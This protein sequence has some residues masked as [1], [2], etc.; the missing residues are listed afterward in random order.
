M[1]LRD[2]QSAM[3]QL[4][5]GCDG[6]DP[7][8]DF[9]LSALER[10]YLSFLEETAGFEFTVNLQRSWC[11]AR[12]AKAAFLTLSILPTEIRSLMLNEWLSLGGG[13]QSSMQAEA[14]GFLRFIS[15]RL[16]DPS[17]EFSVCMLEL[18]ALKASEGARHFERPSPFQLDSRHCLL[19][20]GHYAGLVRF[21][22][23][24]QDLLNALVERVPL[25]PV[26]PNAAALLVA[27][28][29]DRFHRPASRADV[30]IYE[31]LASP[32]GVKALLSEGFKR[33]SIEELLKDGVVEYVQ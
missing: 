13:T 29:L 16:T 21:H 27:P 11:A 32:M 10:G 24:P 15:L 9:A 12:A 1:A 22:A 30:T 18:A 23:P 14:E 25:P 28:G 6:T 33:A 7:L 26:S 31:Q 20:R 8:G 4:I 5:R 19:Q 17:H 3:G 2:F